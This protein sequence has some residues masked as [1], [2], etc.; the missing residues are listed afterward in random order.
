MQES[1]LLSRG[2]AVV[3]ATSK[4]IRAQFACVRHGDKTKNWR[5]LEASSRSYTGA[6]AAELA[7]DQAEQRSRLPADQTASKVGYPRERH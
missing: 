4:K 7:A 1:D 5:G 3:T 2:F 6:E